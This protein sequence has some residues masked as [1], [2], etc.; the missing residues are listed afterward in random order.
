MSEASA[1]ASERQRQ[2]NENCDEYY[3]SLLR[4]LLFLTRSLTAA[5]EIAQ[6][7]FLRFLSR[8]NRAQWKVE[9]KN[10]KAY[11]MTTARRLCIDMWKHA[12]EDKLVSYDDEQDEQV[13]EAL[14]RKAKECDETVSRI[15]DSILY[16]ELYQSLPLNII[17][18][19]MSEY[20][21]SILYMNAVDEMSPEEIALV[22]KESPGQVRYDIQK[23]HSRLAYR[24]RKF[25]EENGGKSP[26]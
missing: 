15:E 21:K 22:V 10:V 13:Q 20:E 26:L 5:E 7:T 6:T 18:A 24:V 3:T 1:L 25:I 11:L 19:G 12:G 8:M 16:K 4:Y 14:Q 9:V 23:I 2:F 17:L